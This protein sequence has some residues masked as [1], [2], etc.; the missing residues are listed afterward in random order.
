ME[1]RLKTM[2]QEFDE[3]KKERAKREKRRA[4]KWAQAVAGQ[5][6]YNFTDLLLQKVFGKNYPQDYK[7][8]SLLELKALAQKLEKEEAW[9][10]VFRTQEVIHLNLL[11][12]F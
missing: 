6:C 7:S 8:Q 9:K 4:T 10:Q 3:V 5:A 1:Q 2:E 12:F 11:L